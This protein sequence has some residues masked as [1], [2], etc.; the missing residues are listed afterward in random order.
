MSVGLMFAI[1]VGA[2]VLIVKRFMGEPVDARDTFLTPLIL[3]GIGV[4]SVTKVDDLSA[5][6]IVWLVIGGVV[7]IAFGAV[8]GT[9]TVLFDRDGHLWQRYTV[10]TL[11]VWATSIVVGFGISLLGHTMGMHHDA[12]PITL[13]IGI[14]MLGEMLTLG[15]RAISTGVPF[16]PDKKAAAAR[17]KAYGQRGEDNSYL[18]RFLN[19]LG[20]PGTAQPRDGYGH[21]DPAPRDRPDRDQYLR[22][23]AEQPRID[24][25]PSLRDGIDW[26][27][28][29]RDRRP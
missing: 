8:R 7:G 6:D 26:L 23:P 15:L 5:I 4:Y 25:S 17:A 20:H 24:R 19:N 1:I 14:G 9:T 18:D 2:I 16:A 29:L 13:S 27:N 11:V 22:K 12:K 28:Q 3:V 10:K 21:T